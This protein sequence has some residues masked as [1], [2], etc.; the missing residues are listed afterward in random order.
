MAGGAH[1]FEAGRAE[2]EALFW[3]ER[4]LSDLG[5]AAFQAR[6]ARLGG[7]VG[8]WRVRDCLLRRPPIR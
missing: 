8:P 2:V 7:P 6:V 5:F 3:G 4:R 1:C